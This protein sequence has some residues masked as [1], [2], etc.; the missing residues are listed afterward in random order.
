MW[1]PFSPSQRPSQMKGEELGGLGRALKRLKELWPLI[2]LC[3]RA[4]SSF[5]SCIRL[6][7]KQQFVV[8]LLRLGVCLSQFAS[9]VLLRVYMHDLRWVSPSFPGLWAGRANNHFM[10]MF[11]KTKWNKGFKCLTGCL[12]GGEY[13]VKGQYLL[14]LV[15]LIGLYIGRL[16]F[17]LF[18]LSPFLPPSLP[19]FSTFFFQTG[20]HVSE[21][22]LKFTV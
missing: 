18:F 11:L 1:D 2:V 14:S 9:A 5:C 20:Y 21:S 10:T 19:F 22:S 16:M 4:P 17:H 3:S 15:F 12:A 13:S 7:H 8:K 6:M